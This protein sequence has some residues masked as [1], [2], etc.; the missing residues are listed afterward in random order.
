MRRA[1]TGTV[2]AAL[3]AKTL[4]RASGTYLE[5]G[6]YRSR[7]VNESDN[8]GGTFYLALCWAKALADQYEDMALQARFSRVAGELEANATAIAGLSGGGF[9]STADRAVMTDGSG[10]LIVSAVT[11]AQL[12]Y[13]QN[14]TSDV[15]TQLDNRMKL[16]VS[17]TFTGGTILQKSSGNQLLSLV[18]SGQNDGG[19]NAKL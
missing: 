4:A 15:Q 1:Q 6:R 17:Q 14:T 2:K 5:N 18:N 12:E 3:R 9:N 8:R 13:L 16:D 11:K 7:I 10:D 19:I